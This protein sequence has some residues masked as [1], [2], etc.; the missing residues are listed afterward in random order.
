MTDFEKYKKKV[1]QYYIIDRCMWVFIAIYFFFP[2]YGMVTGVYLQDMIGSAAANFVEAV[3]LP[4][5]AVIA[6]GYIALQKYSK[7]PGC[8][9]AIKPKVILDMEEFRCPHCGGK[10]FYT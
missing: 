6:C 7:C 10:N 4:M 2:M 5:L 1:K 9:Q 3:Q 8:R